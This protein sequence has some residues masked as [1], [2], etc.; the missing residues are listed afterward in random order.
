MIPRLQ[1]VL[2]RLEMRMAVGA[3]LRQRIERD[4]GARVVDIADVTDL[5]AS[6]ISL[7]LSG[8]REAPPHVQIAIARAVGARVRD[9][10]PRETKSA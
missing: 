1:I 7:I 10:W 4:Y 3:D 6:Y 8:R 9:L 2:A 5:S